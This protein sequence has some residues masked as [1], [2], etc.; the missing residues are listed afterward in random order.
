[1]K[2][3]VD[4]S[5]MAQES[6]KTNGGPPHEKLS[7][8]KIKWS[9]Y[10]AEADVYMRNYDYSKAEE[11]FSLALDIE[12]SNMHAL[13]CRSQVRNL[14]GD[15]KKAEEDADKIISIDPKS[16]NGHMCKANA[17]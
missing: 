6:I 17:L 10:V 16:Q 8:E 13:T 4:L 9:N 7:E 12:P 1:M 15:A 5:D 14:N 3:K 11:M 2:K